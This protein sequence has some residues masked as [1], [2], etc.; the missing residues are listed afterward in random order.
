MKLQGL[1]VPERIVEIPLILEKIRALNLSYSSKFLEIGAVLCTR[2]WMDG[3][4]VYVVDLTPD[5]EPRKRL[6]IIRGNLLK[7]NLPQNFFEAAVSISTIEHLGLAGDSNVRYD[8]DEQGVKKI[9]HALKPNGS[10]LMS[11]PFGKYATHG[12]YRVYDGN[13]IKRLLSPFKRVRLDTFKWNGIS[14]VHCLRKEAESTNSSD[15]HTKAV[16]IVNATK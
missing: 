6:V 1:Y 15:C 12:W 10:L 16:A 14:W 5:V 13:S 2:L 8:A 7:V 9:Y 4:K 11:L 3:Y